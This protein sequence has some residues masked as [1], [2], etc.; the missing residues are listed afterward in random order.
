VEEQFMQPLQA[1]QAKREEV[2]GLFK[3]GQQETEMRKV[4]LINAKKQL[5]EVMAFTQTA[6]VN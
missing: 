3:Q 4:E 5:D 6:L 2:L 1:K